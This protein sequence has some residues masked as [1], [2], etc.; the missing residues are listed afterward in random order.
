MHF[1]KIKDKMEEI[2]KIFA[3]KGLEPSDIPKGERF[4]HNDNTV[5]VLRY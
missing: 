2:K 3:E 5:Q 4:Y 1:Q